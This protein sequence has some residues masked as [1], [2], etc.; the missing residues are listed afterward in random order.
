MAR[1]MPVRPGGFPKSAAAPEQLEHVDRLER[2]RRVRVRTIAR[3]APLDELGVW[4]PLM[5]VGAMIGALARLL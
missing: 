5:L 4:I 3:S 1:S 2:V